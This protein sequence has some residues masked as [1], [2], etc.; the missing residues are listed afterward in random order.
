V[1]LV[2]LRELLVVWQLLQVQLEH[3]HLAAFLLRQE[4]V[5][6]RCAEEFFT[7]LKSILGYVIVSYN[8]HLRRQ[9]VH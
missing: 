5:N 7:H 8:Q 1:P 3:W 4:T 6:T 9:M 2:E